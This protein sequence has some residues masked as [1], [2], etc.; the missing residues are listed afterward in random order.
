MWSNADEVDAFISDHKGGQWAVGDKFVLPDIEQPYQVVAVRPF[1][2]RGKFKLFVDLE[3][4]CAVCDEYLLTTKEV[5]QWMSSPHLMRCCSAHRRGFLTPMANAWKTAAQ[6]EAMKAKQEKVKADKAEPRTGCV[7]DVVLQA[8]H[9]MSLVGDRIGVEYVVDFAVD[10]LPPPG[11]HR[12]DT[13][14]QRVVRA[15]SSLAEAGRITVLGDVVV[16]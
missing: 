15:V 7:E 1:K 13:R 14:K 4:P 12:R 16:L 11:Y 8:M 10:M 6:R 9:A 2:H 3:A 5:H